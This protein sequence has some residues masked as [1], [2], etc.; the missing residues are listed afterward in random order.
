MTTTSTN[1]DYKTWV[2]HKSEKAK[3]V[4]KSEAMKLYARGWFDSPAFNPMAVP[5]QAKKPKK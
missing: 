3:I 5:G 2:Y 1:V 4:Q